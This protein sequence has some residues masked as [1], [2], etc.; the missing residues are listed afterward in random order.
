MPKIGSL[1]ELR[2]L[3]ESAQHDLAIRR[4]TGT[5]ITVGLGTCG[6]AA[7]ARDTL[8]AIMKE[9]DAREIEANVATVGC[10][11]MCSKEPLVDI[12]QAGKPR[13]TYANVH[14]DMVPR[15]IEE[16][17]IN[18]HVVQEWVFGRVSE[19]GVAVPDTEVS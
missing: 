2:K 11:G 6:I 12:E 4:S 19:A 14:P 1:D 13:V 5:K 3:R 10:I 7:G 17:L 9:L 16:H 15:L 8:Q 18:G